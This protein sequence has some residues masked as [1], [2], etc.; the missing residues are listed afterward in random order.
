M[1]SASL[2]VAPSARSLS[3]CVVLFLSTLVT[4]LLTLRFFFLVYT[5]STFSSVL[6]VTVTVTRKM[7]TMALSVF[8]F[9]HS[10]T[11]MQWAGVS[12]VF[13]AIGAEAQIATK[14][15]R[16][17]EAAKRAAAAGKTQ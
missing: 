11:S 17:K 2:R 8:A 13:G 5:L 7:V 15:K 6:L 1:S 10:L 16:A 12:L 4:T 3:V 9:G 14:E